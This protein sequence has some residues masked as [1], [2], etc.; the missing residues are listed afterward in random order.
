VHHILEKLSVH[1]RGEAV[2][3]L[4]TRADLNPTI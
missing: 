4:H 3:W 1:R 2:A